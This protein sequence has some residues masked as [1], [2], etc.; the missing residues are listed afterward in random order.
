VKAT[1]AELGAYTKHQVAGLLAKRLPELGPRQPRYRQSWM[2]EDYSMS[3]FD[4]VALAITFYL[5]RQR[6]TENYQ[7]N[8]SQLNVQNAEKRK[9]LGN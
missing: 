8:Q 4:A 6:R 5:E 3:I 9:D 2:T 7:L 1:F